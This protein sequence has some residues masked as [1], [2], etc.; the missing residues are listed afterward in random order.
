MGGGRPGGDTQHRAHSNGGAKEIADRAGAIQVKRAE[1]IHVGRV[2]SGDAAGVLDRHRAIVV[3][4]AAIAIATAVLVR[5]IGGVAGNGAVGDRHHPGVVVDGAAIRI[6]VVHGA[7]AGQ[8]TVANDYCPGVVVDGAAF[9]TE[10]VGAVTA[11]VGDVAGKGAVGDHQRAEVVDGAA[12]IRIR[13]AVLQSHVIQCQRRSTC[14][15]EQTHL[16]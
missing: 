15:F 9:A 14:H 12:V 11:V 16:I 1:I 10:G 5:V 13:V 6:T 3:D 4:A 2:V 7:V 8:E